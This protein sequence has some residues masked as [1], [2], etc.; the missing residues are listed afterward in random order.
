MWESGSGEFV[1][2]SQQH[3]VV[4]RWCTAIVVEWIPTSVVNNTQC[5]VSTCRFTEAC[6]QHIECCIFAN[7]YAHRTSTNAHSLKRD[8]TQ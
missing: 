6:R 3:G 2:A 4:T 5:S 7:L 8:G 1:L